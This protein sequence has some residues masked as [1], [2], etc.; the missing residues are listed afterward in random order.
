MEA[1]PPKLESLNATENKTYTPQEGYWDFSTV[2]VDVPTG[3]GEIPTGTLTIVEQ[4]DGINVREY[5]YVNIRIPVYKG[6]L[7]NA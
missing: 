6:A 4:K 3:S 2:V 1:L 5:E 7:E